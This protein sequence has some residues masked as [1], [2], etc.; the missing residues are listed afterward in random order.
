LLVHNNVEDT[1]VD[2]FSFIEQLFLE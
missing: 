1:H 2:L